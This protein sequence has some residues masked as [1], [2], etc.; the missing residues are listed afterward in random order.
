MPEWR[1]GH[2]YILGDL[3][4]YR[5]TFLSCGEVNWVGGEV[6]ES[7]LESPNSCRVLLRVCENTSRCLL[8]LVVLVLQLG[9]TREGD[10][11]FSAGGG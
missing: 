4:C 6:T 8:V 3:T 2:C 9:N 1:E 7:L 11:P 10:C 5:S